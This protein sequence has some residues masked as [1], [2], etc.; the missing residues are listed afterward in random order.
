MRM[1]S[2]C[3]IYEVDLSS[4]QKR[5]DLKMYLQKNDLSEIALPN[6]YQCK[7]V[8]LRVTHITASLHAGIRPSPN[9]SLERISKSAN[10]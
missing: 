5:S 4:V 1:T 2:K 6:T 3:N 7:G 9:S 10:E 8:R